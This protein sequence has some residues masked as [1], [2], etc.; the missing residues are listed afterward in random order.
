MFTQLIDLA[1]QHALFLSIA[2]PISL[3][4][5]VHAVIANWELRVG[6]RLPG[7]PYNPFG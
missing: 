3:G 4:L 2:I 6:L 5:G 7:Q 1:Q